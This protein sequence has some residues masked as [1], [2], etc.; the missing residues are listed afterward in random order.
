MAMGEAERGEAEERVGGRPFRHLPRTWEIRE[1]CLHRMGR[2]RRRAATTTGDGAM[3]RGLR[4][5]L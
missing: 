5:G 3:G 2:R 4:E 1:R